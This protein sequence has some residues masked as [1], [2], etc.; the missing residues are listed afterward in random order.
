MSSVNLIKKC[1]AVLLLG[2][3]LVSSVSGT[4][5]AAPEPHGEEQAAGDDSHGEHDTSVPLG[6][7]TD[8]VLWSLV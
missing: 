6:W 2:T 3:L 1:L 8:L 5:L 7:Q 4:A